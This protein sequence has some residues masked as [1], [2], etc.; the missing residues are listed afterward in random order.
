MKRFLPYYKYLKQVKWQFAIAVLAGAVFGVSSGA[1]LPWM[2]KT[3]LP[4]VF[5][6]KEVPLLELIAVALIMPAVFLVRGAS[7]F[8]NTYYI[9][10]CGNKVLEF[11]Q[12]DLFKRIQKLPLQFFHKHKS[13]D[14]ISR[15]MGDTQNI[16]SIIVEASNDVV[17]QPMQLIGALGYL[18]W[19]SCKIAIFSSFSSVL[20]RFRC[21]C[22]LSA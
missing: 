1:G 11:I 7:Q 16:R 3:V 14:L 20:L 4:E 18:V 6:Q 21:V 8:I 19:M 2:M 5:S 9:A 15:L 17:I 13:G 10:Y 12:V 22:F